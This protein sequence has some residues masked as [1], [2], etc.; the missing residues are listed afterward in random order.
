MDSP[1]SAV[2]P[3]DVFNPCTWNFHNGNPSICG[4]PLC[5]DCLLEK[6]PLENQSPHI[7]N[8]DESC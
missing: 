4:S 1:S 3:M 5:A 2:L 6:L 7:L 8:D